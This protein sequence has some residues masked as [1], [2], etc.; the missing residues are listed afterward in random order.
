VLGFYV[1]GEGALE[2]LDLRSE[3]EAARAQHAPGRIIDLFLE[4]AVRG[5][6]IK[7]RHVHQGT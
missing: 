1:L 3:N 7:E 5:I 4:L 2:L 6:E